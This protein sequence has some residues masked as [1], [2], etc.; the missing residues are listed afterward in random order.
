MDALRSLVS[1]LE[2]S[3]RGN[4]AVN[5]NS[6]EVKK[7]VSDGA[8]EYFGT[9][10]PQLAAKGTADSE[11][12]EFD[13]DWKRL[14]ALTHSNNAKS[15]YSTALKNIA[16]RTKSISVAL[17]AAPPVGPANQSSAAETSVLTV[18]DELVPSGGASYRQALRDL[19]G[20]LRASY[21]GTA[22]ELRECLREVLDRLAPD[23]EVTQAP[24]FKL[25]RDRTRPTMKQQTRHIL[26]AR[27]WGDT[28]RG[29]TEKSVELVEEM[30]GAVA[31]SVYDRAS[32]S[33]HT[34][35]SKDEVQRIKRYLDTL[36]H[37]LLD[38]ESK[39]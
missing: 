17:L 22:T 5:I 12:K 18:L 2:S 24:G 9:I 31:R 19:A 30:V 33:T 15:S 3:V 7:I 16:K 37:D 38:I 23:E 32:L 26:K 4:R 11:L 1:R 10:R 35:S 25:E 39:N 34:T 13:A 6:G 21:R 36:L 20:S 27:G 29:A 28:A 8:Q 14:A